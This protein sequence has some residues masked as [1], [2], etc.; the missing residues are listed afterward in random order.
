MINIVLNAGQRK[1]SAESMNDVET[2][3]DFLKKNLD[4]K[5]YREFFLKFKVEYEALFYETPSSP[6]ERGWYEPMRFSVNLV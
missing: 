6:I 3:K 5:A 2:F 4:S 1:Y